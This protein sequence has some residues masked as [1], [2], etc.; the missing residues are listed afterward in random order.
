MAV[1]QSREAFIPYS[2]QEIIEFCLTDGKIAPA[3]QQSFRDFCNILAAYYHFKC[4]YFLETLK[5]NFV[6]FN[7]ELSSLNPQNLRNYDTDLLQK[8]EVDFIEAFTEILIKA[9][10]YPLPKKLLETA[11]VD[12]S[13]FELRTEVDFN[14]FERMICYCR[15]DVS[16]TTVVKRWFFKKV[17]QKIDSFE[18]VVLLIKFKEEQHFKNKPTAREELAFKPGKMY[19]YL[20]KNLSKLDIE[21]IFPNVKMSMTWKDRLLFGLPAIGAGISLIIRILPQI[22]LIIGVIIYLI[23]GSQPI[24]E[25][26]VKE[27]DV[28]DIAP[29]LI[30]A[31]SLAI[32]LGGFAF[33]QYNKYKYKQIKFQKSVTDTLFYRNLASSTGVFQY[34][35]DAA[36][37]EE[38][39]EII[40]VYYHLLTSKTLLTPSTLDSLIETWMLDKFNTKIN[41]DIQ[42]AV[43]NLEVIQANLKNQTN[44]LYAVKPVALLKRDRQNHCQVLSLEEA[45]QLIDYIWDNIFQYTH[46]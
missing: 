11:L 16:Q 13:L 40:L 8:M 14:D 10:Y 45:K 9:N 46:V 43:R 32:T 25:L 44:S 20:Y 19:V 18:R 37:E 24:A 34:L 6:P 4:H 7:P 41:F 12:N 21:F 31:L 36:E 28:R 29:L 3:Q 1:N 17:E 5:T 35:I 38:C 15:G 27:E 42:K 26:A 23:L 39:K 22:V 30:A 2:R 33:R